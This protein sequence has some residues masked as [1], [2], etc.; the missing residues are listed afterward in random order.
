MK[1]KFYGFTNDSV[2]GWVMEDKDFCKYVLQTI[3]P[4]LNIK[5]IDFINRQH[6]ISTPDESKDIRLDIL[7]KDTDDRL[8]DVEM[9]VANHHNL[10]ERMR[11]YQSKID[12]HALR[13]GNGYGAIK[14]SYVIFLCPFDPLDLDWFRYNFILVEEKA[15]KDLNIVKELHDKAHRIIIN[16]KGA[17]PDASDDLRALADLMNGHPRNINKQMDYAIKE[18]ERINNDPEKRRF[19][20]SEEEKLNDVA[21]YNRA[22]GRV[23]ERARVYKEIGKTKQEA[24]NDINALNIMDSETVAKIVNRIYEED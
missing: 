23:E 15:L 19:L 7:V 18:I 13:K 1:S 5:D 9:Q 2:F 11:F 6:D 21:S 17:N 16:S 10:G 8:Y 4:E 22:K 20:M 24:L 14:E 3:L 12:N